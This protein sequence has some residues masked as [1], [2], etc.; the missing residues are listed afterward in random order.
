MIARMD[1]TRRQFVVL[2]AAAPYAVDAARLGYFSETDAT[3]IEAIMAR[4]IPTDQD[5]G[6]R[7][8]GCLYYL[9]TQ[10]RGALK[11][12]AP[13]YESGLRGFREGN[14]KFL[15]LDEAGQIAALE[16]V[17]K[18]PFFTM[19]VDHTMQGFYGS[20]VHGGNKDEASWKMMRIDKYM[21]AG[22]WHGA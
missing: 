8:A 1:A 9:D 17:E 11:R 20:P 18:S 6:A 21:G 16:V 5:P 15:E 14:P 4:I 2:A 22:H 19:L 13:A 7:E 10:L 12:F 3:W